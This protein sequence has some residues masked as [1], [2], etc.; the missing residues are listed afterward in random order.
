MSMAVDTVGGY[1]SRIVPNEQLLAT[2][3]QESSQKEAEKT[4]QK[5]VSS[6]P[7]QIIYEEDGASVSIIEQKQGAKQTAVPMNATAP[8]TDTVEIS[9]E[10]RAASARF[11]AQRAK[12]DTAEKTTYETEDLSEYTDSELKLMYY[13]SD[14]TLQEYEDETGKKISEN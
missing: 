13:S 5:P 8:H 9:E 7:G 11:Q 3:K 4:E 6:R 10:G 14:I 1:T 2:R 12:T